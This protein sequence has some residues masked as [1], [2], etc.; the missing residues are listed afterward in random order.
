M[1]QAGSKDITPEV[2]E[3]IWN[4]HTNSVSD[5]LIANT[6]G[7]SQASVLR[8]VTMMEMAQKGEAIDSYGGD[9]HKR[10]KAYIKSF[11]GVKEEP[12]TKK[13]EAPV[14]NDDNLKEFAA[15]VLFE[16]SHT[17]RLLERL[18][19]ELGVSDDESKIT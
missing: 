2:M 12:K 5:A 19:E 11:W 16:L 14:L 4:L 7:C 10:M 15:R 3:K 6:L 8:F 17:N 1:R 9:N 18:L 13:E